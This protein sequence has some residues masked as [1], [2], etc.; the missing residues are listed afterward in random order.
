MQIFLLKLYTFFSGPCGR[1]HDEGL[2]KSY[3][4]SD[5][6]EKLGYERSFYNFISRL[7]DDMKRKIIRNKERLALTQGPAV[8]SFD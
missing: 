3:R 4:E 5:K 7:H 8:V 1:I 2:K 6:F